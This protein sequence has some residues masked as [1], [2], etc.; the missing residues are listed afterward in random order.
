MAKQSI[1]RVAG[2]DVSISNLDKIMYPAV[3]FTKGQVIDYF[4]RIGRHILPHLKDRPITMKRFPN[5]IDG[6]YFYEKDAPSFTP[7]WIKTY[8]IPRTSEKSI[9]NYIL[10]NDLPT[11]VWS[12]NMANLEIHLLALDLE[13][14]AAV[15]HD[16]HLI[17]VMRLLAIGLRRDE[18]V[19]AD[20]HAGRGVDDLVAAVAGCEPLGDLGDL[21][22]VHRP[23]LLRP[24]CPSRREPC[25]GEPERR[26]A[27]E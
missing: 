14:A 4:T 19:H 27:A 24:V 7:D 9:I 13:R 25:G 3:G 17:A 21:D 5:G 18:H 20:L 12:A 23:S 6:E 22:R 11:L 16:V 8:P 1:L 10:I 26:Q 2:R 15:E